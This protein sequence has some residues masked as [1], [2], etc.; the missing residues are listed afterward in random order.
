[1]DFFF[2]STLGSACFK[3]KYHILVFIHIFHLELLLSQLENHFSEG[4][5][6][7]IHFFAL[8]SSQVVMK[9]EQGLYS[10]TIFGLKFQKV[11]L[12]LTRKHICSMSFLYPSSAQLVAWYHRQKTSLSILV[13][14]V[15]TLIQS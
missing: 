4:I 9:M 10:N 1:M 6:Y 7:T 15:L 11:K 14:I 8:H 12:E 3:N 13:N 5:N 2:S